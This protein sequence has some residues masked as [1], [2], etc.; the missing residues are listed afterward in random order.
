MFSTTIPS[1][2]SSVT[3]SF[4]A[5]SYIRS[6]LHL[7]LPLLP[8]LPLPISFSPS[9]S[10]F[11]LSGSFLSFCW[12]LWLLCSPS[13]L[14]FLLYLC[15]TSFIPFLCI[16]FPFLSPF[17]H[18]TLLLLLSCPSYV[19]TAP[20]P[21]SAPL[22]LPFPLLHLLHLLPLLSLFIPFSAPYPSS[23]LSAISP[24]PLPLLILF[25]LLPHRPLLRLLPLLQN[26]I[27]RTN[28]SH[29]GCNLQTAWR[30][31]SLSAAFRRKERG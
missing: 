10:P 29:T 9:S 23:S 5:P 21:S 19:S 3:S 4:S 24:S 12:F 25:P 31:L 15:L 27:N 13:F 28:L 26:T 7:L 2:F 1:S 11:A 22:L 18:F 16:L 20:S 30:N 14:P 8:L 6:P 17:L